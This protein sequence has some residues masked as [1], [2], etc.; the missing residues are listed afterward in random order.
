MNGPEAS[1]PECGHARGTV[2]QSDS[3]PDHRIVRRRR[4]PVCRHRWH[5]IQDPESFID[6]ARLRYEGGRVV[7]VL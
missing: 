3:I 4:C 1:C 5:T 6:R 7:D 2:T